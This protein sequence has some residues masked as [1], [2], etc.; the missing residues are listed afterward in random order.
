MGIRFSANVW[1]KFRRK[2]SARKMK[3]GASKEAKKARGPQ[4]SSLGEFGR[5]SGSER[6]G[7]VNGAD[8]QTRGPS[9][10]WII[11]DHAWRIERES[12][13]RLQATK[14]RWIIRITFVS[15]R[16]SFCLFKIISNSSHVSPT[17]TSFFSLPNLLTRD[18]LNNKPQIAR[19]VALEYAYC[20]H[21]N[22]QHTQKY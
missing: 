12:G 2:R 7:G 14:R 4:P 5:H 19:L 9:A 17:V 13:S 6:G 21:K 10:I 20:S 15:R 22:T 1:I 16:E 8:E 18:I 11:L 3:L